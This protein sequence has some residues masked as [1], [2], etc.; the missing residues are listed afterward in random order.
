MVVTITEP[1]IKIVQVGESITL[2]CNVQSQEQD[3]KIV[4]SKENGNL[5]EGRVNS[6]NEGILIIT[7]VQAEDSGVYV[8]K[9]VSA[10]YVLSDK[11]VVNVG[12]YNSFLIEIHFIYVV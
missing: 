5:P 3:V 4:W 11:A 10:Y 7:N 2:K 1:K 8:C 6:G 9:A 12:K